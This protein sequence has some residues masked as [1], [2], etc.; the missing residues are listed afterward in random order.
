MP[1]LWMSPLLS[2]GGYSSE[3]ISFAIGLADQPVR[4]GVRQFAEQP[5][6]GFYEG[7][8]SETRATLERLM[9]DGATT[10]SEKGVV[11][12]HSTPDA[13]KPSKFP[14]WDQIAPCPPRGA[15]VTVGRTMYETDSLPADWVERCNR[16]DEVWVPTEF[17]RETFAA[18]GVDRDR[19]AVL[20]EPVDAAFFNPAL[21]EPLPLPLPS[22]IAQVGR[23][24]GGILSRVRT[25]RSR[26][27]APKDPPL[28]LFLRL[29][30]AHRLVRR[31]KRAAR[32]F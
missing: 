30:R 28:L 24:A 7:L 3:A 29:R 26:G 19:L 20:G 22:A 4:F 12:C 6:G 1:L 27:V 25:H 16:M 14:G 9:D 2:G 10:R 32:P 18:A 13:W 31:R 23:A 21:Y 5:D 11:V 8:P 15:K 17:H